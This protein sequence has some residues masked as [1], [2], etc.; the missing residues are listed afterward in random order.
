VDNAHLKIET[1]STAIG[2][3]SLRNISLSC[4]KGE[5]HVLLG[6][7]GSGK[8]SLMKCIL[9]FHKIQRGAIYLG[10]RDITHERP[11]R[12][13]M[14][15]VPQNYSL[16]PHL[17]VEG[18]IRFGLGAGKISLQEEADLL[19]NRLCNMLHIENLRHRKVRNLSGGERQKVALA[20]ALAVQP[21]IILLDEPFSSIDEGAKR[22][23]WV[24][25][26]QIVNEVGITAFHITH[27]LEEAYSLGERLS[28]LINGE[29]LQSGAESDIF[30]S[31]LTEG[32][33]RYL[34]YRNI[35]SGVPKRHPEGAEIDMG[36]FSVFVPGEMPA[37]TEIKLCI[38]PQDIKIIREGF[39]IGDSLKRNVFSGEITSLF[40]FPEYCLMQFRI[41]A[42]PEEYDFEIRVPRYIRER[43]NL[44]AGKSVRVGV[45]E[46]KIILF[47]P[48]LASQR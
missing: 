2:S 45:W 3:F 44:Y 30:E 12:R 9:G 27:N 11:E 42:S 4:Q 39:P 29:L 7:T 17:D 47:S 6:P 1:L 14:A 22:G 16:F 40:L 21:E 19:V 32:I 46:P 25:L 23:L 24:E 20:R 35:F 31:P 43:H 38:R 15:Y 41:E 10:D 37:T 36:Y 28:V 26:K 5:Y 18:N 8:T 34:G 48:P 13:R 33:A